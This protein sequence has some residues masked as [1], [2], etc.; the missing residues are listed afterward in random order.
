MSATATRAGKS[1][2]R[3]TQYNLLAQC[4]VRSAIFT[5]SPGPALKYVVRT[6][7]VPDGGCRPSRGVRRPPRPSSPDPLTVLPARLPAFLSRTASRI[8]WKNRSK[9][10]LAELERLDADVLA[11]QEMDQFEEFWKPWLERRGYGGVYKRRTQATAAKKDGCGLFFKTGKL[12]LLARRGLEYN[13]EAFAG[14]PSVE[15]TSSSEEDDEK[16]AEDAPGDTKS[17]LE[18]LRTFRAR[19]DDSETVSKLPETRKTHV[20][21][22]VGILAMLR[23]KRAE[24]TAAESD[25]DDAEDDEKRKPF[26]VASTHLFWD[27]DFPDVKLRQ[28]ERLLAETRGFVRA[29]LASNAGKRSAGNAGNAGDAVPGGAKTSVPVIVAGDFNSVPGSDV[30]AAALRGVPG[31]SPGTPGTPLKSAYAEALKHADARIAKPADGRDCVAADP[32]TGEPRHTNVTPGFT[33][34]IDYVFVSEDVAVVAA[35]PISGPAA[36]FAGLPDLAHPSDHLPI[37]VTLEY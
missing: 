10:L 15:T 19:N 27:P 32:T 28:T 20:R 14:E 33:E 11:V 29:F 4:Y 24:R 2:V 34:C 18:S 8:R 9:A 6:T 31:P 23:E 35:E 17:L 3:V 30:H 16:R 26:L 13:D 36:T 21:D 1:L 7:R 22:G 12:E 25:E 5:H 37:T